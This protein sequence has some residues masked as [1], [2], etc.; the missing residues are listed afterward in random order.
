MLSALL[1][2]S[3]SWRLVKWVLSDV[4]LLKVSMSENLPTTGRKDSLCFFPRDFQSVV[5]CTFLSK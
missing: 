1:F 3:S 4:V 5:R 2:I